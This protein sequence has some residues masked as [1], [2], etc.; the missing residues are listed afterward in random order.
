[1]LWLGY[2]LCGLAGA[3]LIVMAAAGRPTRGEYMVGTHLVTGPLAIAFTVGT[4]LVFLA[5]PLPHPAAKVGM[6]VALPG[7][8]IG[9]TI[10]PLATY[11]GRHALLIKLF[12]PLVVVSPLAVGH[13]APLHWSLP[14]LGTALLATPAAM[15]LSV[16]LQ[17]PLRRLYWRALRLLRLGSRGPSE[18]ELGQ[19]AV[20]REQWAK[21][22]VDA[23][24][25]ELLAHARSLAP[26]VRAACH[27]RLAAHPD[28][29]PGLG[30]ALRGDGPSNALWYLTHHAAGDRVA[31]AA[32]L[33]DLLAQLRRTLPQ[34]MRH[35]DHPH[36][37]TGDLVPALEC[38]LAILHAGGDVRGELAAWQQ[39]LASQPKFARLAK[40]LAR[41]L[42]RA[43]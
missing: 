43:G 36:P 2:L 4:L 22:P 24:V 28:R 32:P 20:Q 6:Y 13:G 21:V 14:W 29:V 31:C 40:E 3:L 39:E 25:D 27:A 42:R 15:G 41:W 34:R 8:V 7:L 18:W 23:G 17:N 16:V 38:A 30:R 35:D 19:Q 11:G 1:M 9:M 37:W 12:V 26:D 5:A 33:R 10:L